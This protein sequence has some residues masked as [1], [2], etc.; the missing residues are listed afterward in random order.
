MR[1]LTSLFLSISMV[2]LLSSPAFCVAQQVVVEGGP[3]V[4]K[5]ASKLE[6]F[7]AQITV[8]KEM[9][10]WPL[11]LTC[12]NGYG[13]RHGFSWVRVFLNSP[14]Q[15]ANASGN[16]LAD[17]RTFLQ[18]H[19]VTVDISG[20]V[21]SDGNPLFIEGEG[22][23]GAIFS[24]VLTTVKNELSVVDA[25]SITPGK[26]F[27]IHGTGFSTNREDNQVT[28]GG[29][30]AQVIDATARVI[31][32]KA[33]DDLDRSSKTT[34]LMVNVNGQES[35]AIQAGFAALPPTLIGMSPYGGPMGGVINLRGT[36][37]SPVA[38]ENVVMIGPYP[39]PVV[40]VMDTGTLLVRIPD[41]GSSGGTLPV[42]VTTNGLPSTNTLQFWCTPHY[43][44]GDPNAVE[45]GFD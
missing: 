19:A 29:K 36:N 3:Y 31:K 14:G 35:N 27:F 44:G 32:A 2:L 10:G 25:T 20:M 7:S 34:R 37:F 12:Y 40:S 33:P 8:P 16:V 42:R 21:S 15:P 41:W 6:Q 13:A 28:I 5:S 39:A 18:K 23:P 30:P 1:F 17:E 43:Y 4:I 26:S 45:Y 11:Y 9:R 38:A 22:E 24:W